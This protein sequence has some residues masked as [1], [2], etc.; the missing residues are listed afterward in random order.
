MWTNTARTS[1]VRRF[2]VTVGDADIGWF[3]LV[4]PRDNEPGAVWL[5]LFFPGAESAVVVEAVRFAEGQAIEMGASRVLA[6]I[7]VTDDAA[8]QAL[9]SGG[10]ELARRGRFWRLEIGPN[11]GRLIE[12]EADARR[13]VAERGIA[14]ASVAERGGDRL[15]PGVHEVANSAMADIPSSVGFVPTGF[16]DWVVWMQPPSVE[17]DRIWV[18]FS[19]ETPVGYSYLEYQP[20]LVHT[21]F[22]GVLAAHRNQGIARALKL[23]T[24]CQAIAL[25]V[26]AVETDNDSENSPI[27]HLN[28]ELGYVET[29]G[30]HEYQK[31][32]RQC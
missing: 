7:W 2:I 14:I 1:D 8:A 31:T 13:R 28:E 15:L 10:Y 30:Q 18:A 19:G 9:A 29:P 20:S 32:V 5:N 16:E 25:D 3:S 21:G 23:A 6:K 24:L 26:E 11:A 12:L 17:L 27:L 22:T 4:Q